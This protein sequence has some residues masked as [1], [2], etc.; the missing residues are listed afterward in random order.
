MKHFLNF[1]LSKSIHVDAQR[2]RGRWVDS[3]LTERQTDRQM[4]GWMDRQTN[5]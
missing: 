2:E 3:R 4:N 5:G 1:F